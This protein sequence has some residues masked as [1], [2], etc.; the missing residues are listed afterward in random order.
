MRAGLE[1]SLLICEGCLSGHAPNMPG[2][3][4]MLYT[5]MYIIH[6]ELSP[7]PGVFFSSFS[8]LLPDDGFQNIST[9]S[10]HTLYVSLFCSCLK[11]LSV[12]ANSLHHLVRVCAWRSCQVFLLTIWHSF[13]RI[14]APKANFSIYYSPLNPSRSH[15]TK[16]LQESLLLVLLHLLSVH[17]FPLCTSFCKAVLPS[18]QQFE[19]FPFV[20]GS[21]VISMKNFREST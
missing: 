21:Y 4:W 10:S 18:W 8:Y 15:V 13:G 14:L 19:L 9:N 16:M 3:R 6:V 11:T 1:V 12:L 20:A 17:L 2:K 5:C 7:G